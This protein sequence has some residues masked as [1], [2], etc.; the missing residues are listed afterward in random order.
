M[1]YRVVIERTLLVL[2]VIVILGSIG[3]VVPAFTRPGFPSGHD[4]G[5]HVTGTYLFDRALGQ[6][7]VPVRWTEWVRPG[8]S[9]PLFNFYPPGLHYLIQIPHAFGL[10]LSDSLKTIVPLMWCLGGLFTFA[11][12]RPLGGLPAGLA[13][14]LF[15][16]SPYLIVDAFVRAAYPELLAVSFAPGLFWS[17]DRLAR[18][19]A[20]RDALLVACFTAA[21]LVSHLLSSLILGP[22]AAAYAVHRLVATRARPRTIGLLASGAVLGAGLAAF[23]VLPSQLELAYVGIGRITTGYFAYQLHFVEP[24]QLLSGAWEYGGSGPGIDDHMSFAIRAVPWTVLAL[25]CVSLPLGWLTR[26]VPHLGSIAF[27]LAAVGIAMWLMTPSSAV[28]WRAIPALAY[29][30]F[31]W[32][33]SMVI[34]V[35]VA[36]LAALLL[37]AVTSRAAR[38]AVVIVAVGLHYQFERDHLKPDLYYPKS[39]ANID[40]PRWGEDLTPGAPAFLER[41]FG[42]PGGQRVAPAGIGRWTIVGG[43]GEVRAIAMADHRLVLDVHTPDGARLRVNSHAF[44]G[45]VTFVDDQS[46]PLRVDRVFGYIEVDVPPGT[47]RVEAR[48]TNT[49]VRTAA[50]AISVASAGVWLFGVG[51]HLRTRQARRRE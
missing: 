31:P 18:S 37:S 47:H 46:A 20:G 10:R 13:A 14:A 39:L 43:A 23:S 50:N 33:Y 29:L 27:W 17:I 1:R 30:Q 36:A 19:G 41:S 40:D 3:S 32:R 8:E 15:V 45:W 44:P 12:L 42:P 9:Q 49:P 5:G 11:W 25:A 7:Q 38:A 28:V 48:F 21:L 51:W 16:L 4:I 24:S 22:V 2:A 26:R 34:S 35:G 6:G